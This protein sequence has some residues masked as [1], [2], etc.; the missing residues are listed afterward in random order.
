MRSAE[1]LAFGV[2]GTLNDRLAAWSLDHGL[3]YRPV[4][5]ASSL[6]NLLRKGSRGL[7]L[8]H[9]G[10]DLPGEFEVLRD[11]VREFHEVTAIAMGDVDH[12]LLEGL[13]DDLGARAVNGEGVAV[14][15]RGRHG[16]CAR[17]PG[18]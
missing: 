6:R 4:Q 14:A 12:P 13:A 8:V 10:R 3:W 7:L 1:L 5:Q 9:L 17:E 2:E 16:W 15:L 18:R 11:T